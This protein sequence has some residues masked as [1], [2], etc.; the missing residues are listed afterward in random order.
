MVFVLFL[1]EVQELQVVEELQLT[2]Q[3]WTFVFCGGF[4]FVAWVGWQ[5]VWGEEGFLPLS[6]KITTTTN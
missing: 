1:D 5:G 3:H 4:E 6:R 2:K